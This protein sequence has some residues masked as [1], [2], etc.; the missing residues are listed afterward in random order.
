MA[1]SL[2]VSCYRMDDGTNNMQAEQ[3]M[4]NNMTALFKEMM[5]GK[6][7][8]MV[9]I[10]RKVSQPDNMLT[11]FTK[12]I[13]SNFV[14]QQNPVAQ[15]KEMLDITNMVKAQGPQD[16]AQK[17]IEAVKL[18]VDSRIAM[19][20]L[21]LKKLE[22]QHN[23]RMDENQSREQD[24]NVDKWL[25]TLQGMGESIIKPVAIKFLE[26]FGK[27]QIPG[28]PLNG[29]FAQPTLQTPIGANE[30]DYAMQ[31]QQYYQNMERER[32]RP[33]TP[34]QPIPPIQQQRQ[35]NNQQLPRQ[36][37][38]QQQQQQPLQPQQ[39]QQ[40]Q[41]TIAAA[42]ERD[43]ETELQQLS[44]QQI[45]D[46]EDKMAI[47]DINREKVKNAIRAYKNGRRVSRPR[48]AEQ[49]E[50]ARNVLFNPPVPEEELNEDDLEF[51]ENDDQE[52]DYEVPIARGDTKVP[53]TTV[54]KPR[55]KF[56]DF[57]QKSTTEIAKTKKLND[58]QKAMLSSG[59]MTDRELAQIEDGEEEEDEYSSSGVPMPAGLRNASED[60][61]VQENLKK[62]K[63][64]PTNKK[65]KEKKQESEPE[66]EIDV[67]VDKAIV[68]EIQEQQEAEAEKVLAEAQ[69]V[70]EEVPEDVFE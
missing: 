7:A 63:Q 46:I 32:A 12:T 48:P 54:Q 18:D 15:I 39:Q 5:A 40:Q 67:D 38:Q 52:E 20:E 65:S 61:M 16:N 59:Q 58:Q 44:P 25:N 64:A 8:E 11:D 62:T 24:S 57:E 27:G 68:N 2:S 1:K 13:M 28:G 49:V 19:Q 23:W 60:I 26:G 69:Q 4:L 51:D 45:Q 56:S 66:P 50:E 37:Q 6:N 41:R 9:E 55:K 22:M 14:T 31:Q 17:S 30:Q 42:S 47:D 21:E 70:I 36:Q 34:M 29:Q 53:P 33:M 3:N 35:F 43:I 10:L